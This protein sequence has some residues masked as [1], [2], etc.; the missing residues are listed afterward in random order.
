M[1]LWMLTPIPGGRVAIRIRNVDD[2]PRRIAID[3]TDAEDVVEEWRCSRCSRWFP[4][5]TI[6]LVESGRVVAGVP[7]IAAHCGPCASG[8]RR[9]RGEP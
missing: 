4:R 6:R 7:E 1:T 9:M 3:D 2:R 8:P 5:T